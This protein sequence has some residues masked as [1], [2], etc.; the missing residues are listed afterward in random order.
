[1]VDQS[2]GI[3]DFIQVAGDVGGQDDGM[4]LLLKEFEE[5]IE[6]LVPH[7]RVEAACGLVEQ[8]QPGMMAHRG[9][10]GELHF[11]PAGEFLERLAGGQAE[12]L[13]I[14]AVEG[15]VPFCVPGGQR[16]ADLKR[17]EEFVKAGFIEHHADLLLDGALILPIVQA[18]NPD[19]PLVTADE[20]ENEFDG[21]GFAG[22]VGAD[23]AGDGARL[24]ME[25]RDIQLK[26]AV[27]FF[28]SCYLQ[29]FAH[30]VSSCSAEPSAGPDSS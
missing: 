22:A 2:D 21:G 9:G 29:Y 7:Q 19:C 26:T 27:P 8:E 20:A 24:H 28:Q 5:H 11:H 4:V 25:V 15:V 1:M 14:V 13:Q 12:L 6:D 16:P 3:G 17:G 23:Q 30:G 10:D 18:E